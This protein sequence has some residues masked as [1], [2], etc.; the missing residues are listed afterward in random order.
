VAAGVLALALSPALADAGVARLWAVNDGE[1]VEQDDL[2]SPLRTRNSAWDGAKVRLFGAK[3]EVIAFQVM[4]EADAGGIAALAA[5]LPELRQRGGAGRIAYAA[6]GPDP[7]QSVG[8][9]IQ[10]FAVHY[11]NV[12][13]TSHADW[14]WKPGSAA[15]P[16]DT[17]G[18]KPVQLVPENARAG[19]GG[20]PLRVAASRNQALWIEVY[21]PRDL[22]AGVYEGVVTVTADDRALRLPVELQLFDFALP[23]ANSMDAMVYY[24]PSQPEQYQGRNLDEVYHRFAHRYRVELVHAY[25][26]A[27]VRAVAGRF[28]GKDFTRGAGYEGPGE[29]VGMRIVPRSF[30]GPGNGWDDRDEA[31]RLADSWITFLGMV[32]PR[33][34]TFLYMPDEPAPAEF[35]RIRTLAANVHSNPGPGKALPVFV[36]KQW[37][38]ELDDAIDIWCAGPQSFDVERAVKERARGRSYWTYNGGRPNGP[39]I[40]IDAP[41]TEA[42]AMAWASFKHD[43]DVYFYW[44]G[45]HWQHNRQK[46]GERRQN[47]WASPI[48]FDNRGQPN[49]D[50]FGYINGDGVLFYPGEEKVHP[51]EDRGIAGPIASVQLAS[52][53]R[54]LQDH[55]YLTMARALGLTAAVDRALRAVVPRVFSEAGETVGFA[56]TGDEYETARLALAN[57]IASS[58]KALAPR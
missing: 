37:V 53:R 34:K 50:D 33:A 1:K 35:P 38:A 25:D 8:R 52:L 15:A 30:Y 44:H 24:E 14:V 3:N 5:A 54:G 46:Q 43:I 26:E 23:D 29:G 45:V 51:Q 11:M 18:W 2:A 42:R 10:I 36:T 32:V 31:W 6:P 21:T 17:T 27:A 48:T 28:D 12:T 39:A 7:S 20:L 16:R 56:E 55:Q 57:A 49:K 19:R 58:G 4:V 47:V 13:E 40:V 41:A 9:P 22:P